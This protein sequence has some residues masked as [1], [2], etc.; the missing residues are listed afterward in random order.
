MH[1]DM[2]KP[3][4]RSDAGLSHHDRRPTFYDI[5]LN[6]TAPFEKDDSLFILD[7][8]PLSTPTNAYDPLDTTVGVATFSVFWSFIVDTVLSLLWSLVFTIVCGSRQ[9]LKDCLIPTQNN[10]SYYMRRIVFGLAVLDG[11]V[12]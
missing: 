3:E 10:R 7:H 11:W 4:F 2:L 9:T 1:K 5:D 6:I 8:F 12:V